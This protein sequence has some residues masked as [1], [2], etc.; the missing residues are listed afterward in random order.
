M[1]LLGW[2]IA[3]DIRRPIATASDG[4]VRDVGTR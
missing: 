4:V 3:V 2:V 1:A